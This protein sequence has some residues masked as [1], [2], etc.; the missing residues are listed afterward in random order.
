M[1]PSRRRPQPL[2]RSTERPWWR[3]WWALAGAAAAMVAVLIVVVTLAG[4]GPGGGAAASPV[5]RPAEQPPLL[6]TSD[7]TAGGQTVDG[8]RCESNEQ[9]VYHIHAHLAVFVDG[10]ARAIPEGIGIPPPRQVEQTPDGPF[11]VGG[12]CYYWLHSH[13]R[14]GIVHIESPTQQIYTLGQYF[15]IWQQPL[16]ATQVGPATGPVIAY[17]N[18]Q[19]YTGDVRA[20]PLNVHAVIQLDVGRDVAPAPFAFPPGL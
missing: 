1:A 20:I 14:D 19:R 16:S 15:D 4:R 2:P 12:R 13:A 10:A 17:V 7:S 8:I 3:A 18:G 5:V 6:A 9:V 11:V